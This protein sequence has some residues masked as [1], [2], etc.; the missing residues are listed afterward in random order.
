MSTKVLT[1]LIVLYFASAALSEDFK[2]LNG[3]EYKDATVSRI[4]PDGIVLTRKLGIV[5]LYFTELP[6][7]VQERFHYDTRKAAA[8]SNAQSTQTDQ[9]NAAQATRTDYANAVQAL[10]AR[11]IQLQQ[12]EDALLLRIGEA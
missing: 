12:E 10:R 8:Y 4:E 6:K 9:A 2:T 1:F 3:K 11:Y 5:K 7:E